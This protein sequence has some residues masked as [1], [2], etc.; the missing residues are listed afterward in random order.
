[1]K[2]ED[3]ELKAGVIDLKEEETNFKHEGINSPDV[4]YDSRV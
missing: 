1:L 3:S 2:T 4:E